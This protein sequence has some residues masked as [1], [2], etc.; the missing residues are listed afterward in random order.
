MMNEKTEKFYH[1]M[2][3]LIRAMTQVNRF[4]K[5]AILRGVAD[6]CKFYGVS[7]AVYE[8]YQSSTDEKHKKG[9][10][11]V[12]FDDGNAGDVSYTERILTKSRAIV[13]GTAYMSKDTPP[14]SPEDEDKLQLVTRM[15]LSFLSRHRL[16]GVVEKY[17]FYDDTGYRNVRSFLRYLEVLSENNS[18]GGH[19][20]LYYNLRHFTLVN[21]DIGRSAGDIA[22]R[23]YFEMIEKIIGDKGTI[24]RV[25]GD[26]FVAVFEDELTDVILNILKGAPVVYD[27]N[28]GKRIMVSANT[29]VFRMHEGYKFDTPGDIMDRI[30]SS[31][32]AAKSGGKDH[33]VFFD[34]KMEISKEKRMLIQQHFPQ[35]LKNEEFKVFYQP[36]IDIVTGEL[37]GGEALCRWFRDGKIVPP[38][39]FIPILEQ[40]T[41]ICQLDFYMLDHVCRDI[42][43]WLDEGRNVVR[44][45]VNLS[46]K[47]MMD[48]DLLEHIIEIIDR[49]N[50]P[51]EYIEIEL[52]ETTTDVE[53][54]DLKRVV[55]S[56][57][58]KGIYTSVDDFGMGYSSLNLIREIP[59]NVLKVD[60]S[61]LPVD[62]DDAES[63]RSVMFK[64][65]VAMAQDLGLECVAEGVETSHQ[66]KV[67]RDN[68]CIFAQGFLFDKPLPLNEFE[69]RMNEHFYKVKDE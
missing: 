69:E 46:R 32:H 12:C 53:F 34:E 68:N 21:R 40:N 16:E 2:E 13:K 39:E 31:S 48:V 19:T 30:L 22:M 4:D 49:N 61:F 51:H 6:M 43:R 59:W 42:R 26:N 33:V 11:I 38:M 23:N 17:T 44:I 62:D 1:L 50:V 37:V 45:S 36:K 20:A 8:F 58:Q 55:S 64:Y 3:K 56:L 27:N 67:L 18:L 57:Q 25:G 10:K 29:G 63:T 35:A 5:Y 14:L 9:D 47:H 28:S 7:M 60:R 65:V 15:L 66:V 54:R 24:C 41:D 52:T